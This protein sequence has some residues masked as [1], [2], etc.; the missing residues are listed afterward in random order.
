M[1]NAFLIK[2]ASLASSESSKVQ[3]GPLFL[4]CCFMAL[5]PCAKVTKRTCCNHSNIN[6]FFHRNKTIY[7]GDDPKNRLR[8]V[9]DVFEPFLDL[10]MHF[11]SKFDFSSFLHAT[12]R[13][14][15]I[16]FQ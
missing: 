1:Q 8:L 15:G 5:P 12:A 3:A 9:V 14:S 6:I 13:A 4:R 2:D 7:S 10:L 16:G 11:N